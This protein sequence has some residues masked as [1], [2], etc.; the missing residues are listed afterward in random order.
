MKKT[1]LTVTLLFSLFSQ[2]PASDLNLGVRLYSDGLYSLA[3]KTFKENFDSLVGKD[4]K[5]FYRYAYLSFLKGGDYASLERLVKVWKEK[6]P[7]FR[8]GELL[9]LETLIALHRG[10]P[11][12]KAFPQK[13]LLALPIDEKIA[14][15]RVL[16]QADL[17]PEESLFVLSVAAKNTELKGAVKDSGFLKK[18][19]ER[20]VKESDYALID[21]IFDNY[22]RWFKGKE[23]GL[24]FVRYLERKK[25]FAD[26]LVEARKLYKKYPDQE[27]RLELARAYYLSGKYDRVLSLIKKPSNEKEKYLLAW[28]YFRLNRPE[29]IAPLV[30]LNTE[31]P[32]LP[33]KLKVLLDFYRAD[34]NLPLLKKFYPELYPK[35]LIFSFSELLPQGGVGLPHD[36]A[37]I[38][39]E[40]GYFEKAKEEL[41]KAVQNPQDKNLTGRALFLLGRLGSVNTQ[42]GSVVYNQLMANYQGTPYYRES[43][44]PAAK[45]YLYSGSP[46][47][48]L[49]LLSYAYSRL[50]RKNDE[51]RELLGRAYMIE[52]DYRKASSYLAKSG[53]QT[54]K[55]LLAY[56]LYQVGE[57]KKAYE[58]LRELFKGGALFPEVNGGR[59]VF[60]SRLLGKERELRKVKFGVPIP[61]VMAAV[62]GG[63]L[64]RARELFP[65]VPQREKVVLA[66]FLAKSY[67]KSNPQVALDYL[68][69]L[70]DSA[71]DEEVADYG[72]KLLNYLAFKTGNYAPVLFSDPYFI[73]YNPENAIT[74]TSTLLSKAQDY[75]SQ[76][77]P[78]KAYG[79][80]KL[81]LERSS[82][83]SLRREIV[84]RMVEIDLKQK[85][86]SRAL[87]DIALIPQDS[88]KDR[89]LKNFLLFKT[90]L[91]MG[92][93]VDAYESAKKVSSVENL[94][95]D[96]RAPFL[97]KLA[98]YYKLTG[99]KDRAIE[100]VRELL[101]E[102]GISGAD[103]DDLVSL[104]ILAQEKGELSLARKL[105]E[106]AMKKAKTRQ[107]KAES[108]FWKA[109]IESQAGNTDDAIIDYMK[110][111]YDYKG[112]EPWA[113]TALYRA[114]Q[115]FEEKGDYRQALKLYRRVARLKRGTREGEVAAEKVKSLL[116]KLNREE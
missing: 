27:T 106:G 29:K 59:F 100:L 14:F 76:G 85:N 47:V 4:F 39:W 113:S 6:Y 84:R 109:A 61:E 21:F 20:A 89:D 12:E 38:Y 13:E 50:D 46:Q 70:V 77:Q 116:Q 28:T 92:R 40:K 87:R 3:A 81:A 15:F 35:A 71:G 16:S 105:I 91:A 101:K 104:A 36:L 56:S 99:N 67:E 34:F 98:R 25:Q 68:T 55:T 32:Q 10:T 43:I 58:V 107:Q 30:G 45:V 51:V 63:D 65:Q 114:A 57:K 86:Y 23:A 95:P 75:A 83:P 26:A 49:R 96:E 53:S 88:Q 90:Y 62:V 8:K 79:L 48:A 115:L 44:V 60:L 19:L 69:R 73:A 22:G 72:R 80:L 52:G 41:E 37:Y 5:K 11:I 64:E 103:Y 93:L 82:S 18:T 7:D 78:G 42:V 111:A 24:Q 2:A 33:Q 112:V 110:I 66:L 108:L 1:A 102:G 54:G 31:R 74:S 94:P 17:K 97:A 9:A